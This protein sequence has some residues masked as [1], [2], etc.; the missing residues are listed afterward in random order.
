MIAALT[1]NDLELIG[2]LASAGSFHAAA[3]Q[4]GVDATTVA[5][6]LERLER[7]LGHCVFE[8][9]VGRLQPT[10]AVQA[11]LPAIMTMREAAGEA[12]AS[13]HRR[14]AELSGQ[15]RVSTLGII[16]N[17][18]LAPA[19]GAFHALHPKVVLALVAE[20]RSV[21]FE[22][23]EADIAIRLGRPKDDSARIRKLGIIRFRAYV[24]AVCPYRADGSALPVVRYDTSLDHLPEMQLLDKLLPDIAVFLRANRLDVLMAASKATGAV[25]MLP[26]RIG[27][28]AHELT[29]YPGF[30]EFAE[31]EVYLM[32]H[33][34]RI[35]APS[36]R[37]VADWII[38]IFALL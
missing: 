6:R 5:R 33:P 11:A 29:R 15:V 3:L 25:V 34:D 24:P 20:D 7:H 26:E 8:R 30:E 16:Q 10:P 21:S 19:M 9:V 28:D 37:A 32:L 27:D 13:L 4:T 31:R 38:K 2:T 17:H 35:N 12:A 23:R 22:R 36:V 1:W 18:W 14:K